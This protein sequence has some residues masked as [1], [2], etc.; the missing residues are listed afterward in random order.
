M[1]VF[2]LAYRIEKESIERDLFFKSNKISFKRMIH[3]QRIGGH[4]DGQSSTGIVDYSS[5]L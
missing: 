3:I 4:D 1:T 5:E 2:S